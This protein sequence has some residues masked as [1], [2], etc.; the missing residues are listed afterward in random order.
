MIVGR[1]SRFYWLQRHL[2]PWLLG[3]DVGHASPGVQRPSLA[4][5]VFSVDNTFSRYHALAR[6]QQGRMETIV[7]LKMMMVV[8]S[9]ESQPSAAHSVPQ[10]AIMVFYRTNNLTPAR[11]VFFRD[12]VSEGEF[13]GVRD[14]EVQAIHGEWSHIDLGAQP[15]ACP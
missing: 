13:S 4:S 15:N 2:S 3:A 11:I 6:L 8:G 5:V 10:E 14:N 1:C 12:G 7:D 9:N